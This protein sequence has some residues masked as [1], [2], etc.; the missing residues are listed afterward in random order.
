MAFSPEFL[1]MLDK[2]D[3]EE[4]QE[5]MAQKSATGP[6]GVRN[7]S[8]Q[9]LA[10]V[11]QNQEDELDENSGMQGFVNDLSE[12]GN[13]FVRGTPVGSWVDEGVGALYGEQGKQDYLNAEQLKAESADNPVTAPLANLGGMLTPVGALG[14][15]VAKNAALGAGLGTIGGAGM[16]E[17]QGR[18]GNAAMG[19]AIGTGLGAAG[20]YIGTG[21]GQIKS[22]ADKVSG[23]TSKFSIPRKGKVLGV[24]YDFS[25]SA[26]SHPDVSLPTRTTPEVP[27]EYGGRGPIE[28]SPVVED[29]TMGAGPSNLTLNRRGPSPEDVTAPLGLE[30]LANEQYPPIGPWAG[31]ADSLAAQNLMKFNMGQEQPIAYKPQGE[32]GTAQIEQLSPAELDATWPKINTPSEAS[33]SVMSKSASTVPEPTPEAPLPPPPVQTPEEIAG[34]EAMMRETAQDW[35]PQMQQEQ[36]VYNQFNQ[37]L[38]Q[39]PMFQQLQALMSRKSAPPSADYMPSTGKNK[40]GQAKAREAKDKGEPAR[41][42]P[43][44]KR[45]TFGK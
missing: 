34:L 12:L 43:P 18:A 35:R 19:A 33:T 9:N 36:G 16:A 17:G 1:D 39:D 28:T 29:I 2:I 3:A 32:Q 20:G 40:V 7:Q 25:P 30:Q 26:Q 15:G 41:K 45:P 21:G 27:P 10:R 22:L 6:Q 8:R 14:P 13:Q 38:M 44:K 4:E 23:F 42:K 31:E 37:M 24:N 5:E 11:R